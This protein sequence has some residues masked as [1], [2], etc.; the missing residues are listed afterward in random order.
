MVRLME[1]ICF[2]FGA[3]EVT[4][5]MPKLHSRLSAPGGQLSHNAVDSGLLSLFSGV[6]R[7]V[8]HV[9]K[10]LLA[11]PA[12]G[13]CSKP[14]RF[15][16]PE[17]GENVSKESMIPDRQETTELLASSPMAKNK[18]LYLSGGMRRDFS[19]TL[20]AGKQVAG[21]AMNCIMGLLLALGGEW[22]GRGIGKCQLSQLLDAG[23]LT[24]VSGS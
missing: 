21:M 8:Y 2:F 23:I 16:K 19:A 12:T 9:L 10:V 13:G 22:Q 20:A 15:G 1:G 5:L 3:H 24:G 6:L 4:S 14:L 7:G 17:D 18:T 11:N